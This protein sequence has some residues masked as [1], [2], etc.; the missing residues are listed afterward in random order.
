M[1]ELLE[2]ANT[3]TEILQIL[4]THPGSTIGELGSQLGISPM[5]VRQH[6]A[7][8]ERDGLVYSSKRR[9]GTGRPAN[10]YYLTDQGA[11]LFP[12][13]YGAFAEQLLAAVERLGGT[14]GIEHVLA[15]REDILYE[16]YTS[17][18]GSGPTLHLWQSIAQVQENKGYHPELRVEGGE[19]VFRQYNCIVA[20][21]ATKYPQ[22]CAH[23]RQ[24]FSRLVGA[25]V[26]SQGCAAA[27]E[28]PCEFRCQLAN[29]GF[30]H[31][32]PT[33][34]SLPGRD[35]VASEALSSGE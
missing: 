31:S 19:V 1:Q 22:L 27:G 9:G 10:M 29:L 20:H 23:E 12:R 33:S 7:V 35:A 16:Q 15:E 11:E 18:I 2:V 17:Q 4:Q 8:L 30:N 6:V 14:E 32:L 13:A 21:L 28:G 3:R 25:K 34:N 24:L 5:G 26:T